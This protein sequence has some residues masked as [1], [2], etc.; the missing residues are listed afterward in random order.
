MAPPITLH[1]K[2]KPNSTNSLQLHSLF[3]RRLS[4]PT[5][6]EWVEELAAELLAPWVGLHFA[7][8]AEQATP[9]NHSIN[10]LISFLIWL[11]PLLQLNSTL[12][13][14]ASLI[15]SLLLCFGLL[16]SLSG[17]MAAAAAH[18]PPQTRAH[19]AREISLITLLR[20]KWN[21]S[22]QKKQINLFLFLLA[23]SFSWA[24]PR[25]SNSTFQSTLPFSKRELNE[26]VELAA[27]PR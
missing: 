26:R 4:G 7:S 1:K 10:K 9:I 11:A 24:A 17:A 22:T 16:S 14:S 5:K 25:R 19:K 13:S 15:Q 12:L 8:G 21:R 20:E 27:G 6:R 18:N 3:W 2:R 23:H